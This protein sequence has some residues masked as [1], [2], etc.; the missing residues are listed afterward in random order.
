MGKFVGVAP[1]SREKLGEKRKVF[2]NRHQAERTREEKKKFRGNE[3]V[4]KMGHPQEV[5]KK[6]KYR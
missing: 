5:D 2:S 1:G 3:H 4:F 6:R